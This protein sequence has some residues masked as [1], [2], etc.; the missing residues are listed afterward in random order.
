MNLSIS[1][2]LDDVCPKY[3]GILNSKKNVCCN[4]KCP[5]CGG[6]R[7]AQYSDDSG[8]KLGAGKCCPRKILNGRKICGSRG[9]KKAPCKL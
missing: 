1:E 2:L 9:N 7:C 5:K 4:E 6:R 8:N 3:N